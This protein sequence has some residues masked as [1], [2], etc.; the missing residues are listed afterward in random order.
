MDS[1]IEAG[2]RYDEVVARLQKNGEAIKSLVAAALAADE[3]WQKERTSLTIEF[4]PSELFE[5]KVMGLRRRAED[6]RERI[7]RSAELDDAQREALREEAADIYEALGRL[8]E[9]AGRTAIDKSEAR[10]EL[11]LLLQEIGVMLRPPVAAA[12]VGGLTGLRATHRQVKAQYA[13]VQ[14]TLTEEQRRTMRMRIAQLSA[15]VR[16]AEDDAWAAIFHQPPPPPEPPPA[17]EP[18]PQPD[19]LQ[20]AIQLAVARAAE[21]APVVAEA[22]LASVPQPKAVAR[23][24][25]GALGDAFRLK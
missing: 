19:L 2:Q 20:E 15:L 14:H 1:M 4:Q 21:S 3:R 11:M 13:S 6:L 10:D 22:V 5:F 25:F 16:R 24:F 23:G 7:G 18:E 12:S 17:P 9:V 8:D